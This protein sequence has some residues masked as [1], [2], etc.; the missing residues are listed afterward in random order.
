MD[1]SH[2]QT[3]P[4]AAGKKGPNSVENFDLMEIW[5]LRKWRY[6][7]PVQKQYRKKI[8]YLYGN[9]AFLGDGSNK[10]WFPSSKTITE[11]SS[12]YNLV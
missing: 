2:C 12:W 9:L 10:L 5:H 4:L 6:G 8:D 3:M 1:V 11:N 7:F